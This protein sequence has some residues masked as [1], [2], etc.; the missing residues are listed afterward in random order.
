MMRKS[1]VGLVLAFTVPLAF[2]QD[3]R[4]RYDI[5]AGGQILIWN[6]HGNIKVTGYKGNGIEIVAYKKGPDRDLIEIEDRSFESRIEV[7][8]RFLQ[9]GYRNGSVDFEVRVP[10]SIEYN[11][12]RLSSFSG[13]VEVSDVVGMLRAQSARGNV[14]I[15]NVRGLVS[16]SSG[17]GNVTVDIDQARDRSNMK[18]STISGDI[19]VRAPSNLDA[20]VDMSSASGLLRTDF[21][22]EIQKLRYGPG[23][24]ARGRLG[25]GRLILRIS[26]VSGEVS[27]IQK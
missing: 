26:S 3:F 24:S 13:N 7:F 4:R 23:R 5:P 1:L 19:S 16:A 6:Y 8:P 17:S 10:G 2:A 25:S 20:L 15:K 11:F 12:S 21:P 27:L 9:F 18:F 14:E 22:V